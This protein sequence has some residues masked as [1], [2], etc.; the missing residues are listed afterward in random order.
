MIKKY[1]KGFSSVEL[2]I[3]IVVLAVIGFAGYYIAHKSYSN[4]APSS[5]NQPPAGNVANNAPLV[6]SKNADTPA[7]LAQNVNNIT[8]NSVNSILSSS[9]S[10]STN[11]NS[12]INTSTQQDT[13]I[14][15]AYN[16]S[17]L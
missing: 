8:L 10:N 4:T 1:Q 6:V 5:T 14:S 3:V 2:L 15:G 13:N 16:V 17:S 7:S 9:L 12:Q 11:L